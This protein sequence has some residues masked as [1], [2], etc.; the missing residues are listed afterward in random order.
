MSKVLFHN[1]GLL[2]TPL[3]KEAR[4]GEAQGQIERI[5]NC[6]VLCED[7]KFVRIIKNGEP[8]PKAD[9]M[10]DCGGKVATPGLVDCHTHA[11]FGGWRQHELALKLKGA[12]YLDI[13]NAGGGILSTVEKTRAA[14]QEELLSRSE[15]WLGEMLRSGVT[16]VEIKSGYGLDLE[17]ELKQLEV[18]EKLRT[19]TP[20]V[21]KAT[22]LAAHAVPPEYKDKP[23]DFI[24]CI[25]EEIIPAVAQKKLAQFCDV[26][27]E[28]SVFN[29]DQSRKVLL[30]GKE[31]GLIPKIHADEIERIGGAQLAGECGAISAEH[32]AVTDEEG[33]KALANGGVVAALLPATSL[34]LKKGYADARAMIENS[35]PVAIGSDFNP[36]SCPCL[37][38]QLGINLGALYMNMTPEEL[39]CAVTLNAA[40]AV[41]EGKNIGSV[42]PGKKADLVLWNASDWETVCYR[43]GSNLVDSVY[44]NAKKVV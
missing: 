22:L 42:E 18:V 16:A 6:A 9:A 17:N 44:I 2:C 26:F 14:S 34:Y 30:K 33:M 1:I 32:L 10:I 36:G 31:Y 25:C 5:E 43:F 37:S 28:A 41:G 8:M 40:C 29:A 35:V 20:Q 38:L 11:V 27:C 7:G 13:L 39:L 19:K 3:G 4:C 15:E 24:D 23:N 12:T 21:I